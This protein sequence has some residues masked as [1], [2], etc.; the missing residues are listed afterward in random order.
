MRFGVSE[1]ALL[2]MP[3][4][5]EADDI[6]KCPQ[7]ADG[8]AIDTAKKNRDNQDYN[9][10]GRTEGRRIKKFHQRRDEL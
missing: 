9:E 7:G 8:R 10:P 1:A 2:A 3:L 4:E 6:L 5:N